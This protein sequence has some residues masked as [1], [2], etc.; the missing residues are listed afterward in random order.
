MKADKM[1]RSPERIVD[2]IPLKGLA[3]RVKSYSLHRGVRSRRAR[4]GPAPERRRDFTQD[5]KS[6]RLN[7]S[8]Q[9]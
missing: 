7:S 1:M 6:T 8:H 5:R 4:F 3:E 2:R 9:I